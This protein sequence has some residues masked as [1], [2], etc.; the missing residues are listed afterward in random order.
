MI[1]FD[2]LR[3]T[4]TASHCGKP[5][6][7]KFSLLQTFSFRINFQKQGFSIY[8]FSKTFSCDKNIQKREVKPKAK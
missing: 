7:A 3:T 2:I 4:V 1:N 6:T 8:P 5:N